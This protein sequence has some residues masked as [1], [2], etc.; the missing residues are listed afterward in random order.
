M[1]WW[2]ESV[3][4]VSTPPRNSPIYRMEGQSPHVFYSVSLHDHIGKMKEEG[5]LSV[6]IVPRCRGCP[7]RSRR[8]FHSERTEL[9][10]SCNHG[11]TTVTGWTATFLDGKF[12]CLASEVAVHPDTISLSYW[13]G[14]C[15]CG[16][17]YPNISD[18]FCGSILLYTL[19][20]IST[21]AVTKPIWQTNCVNGV[22][23]CS[24]HAVMCSNNKL[25]LSP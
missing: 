7:C 10:A 8:P 22:L 4:V 1:V 18:Y 12:Q 25:A 3:G 21:E 14:D 23:N 17:C 15:F 20:A 6:A 11:W 16:S 19:V 13:F 24:L 9:L 2:T 5:I